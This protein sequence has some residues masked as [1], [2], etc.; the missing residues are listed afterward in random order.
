V[1]G[2]AF[3]AFRGL[4]HVAD[5]AALL[6]VDRVNDSTPS[7]FKGDGAYEIYSSPY[8]ANPHFALET[9]GVSIKDTGTKMGKREKESGAT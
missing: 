8:Y 7:L 3:D 1:V 9:S 2:T 4:P 5:C 6:E